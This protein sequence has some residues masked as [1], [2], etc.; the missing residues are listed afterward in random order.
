MI[1]MKKMAALLAMA[2]FVAVAI[3]AQQAPP[4]EKP[5]NLKV[6]PKNIS[7]KELDK[8]MDQYCAALGV[9]CDFCHV[10][11]KEKDEMNFVKDDKPEKQ[12]TR[13]MMRMTAAVNKTYFS[14]NGAADAQPAVTCA[15]CHRGMA[16]P[17]VADSL[18][19]K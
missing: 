3:A 1:S 7:P 17:G 4:D 16:R 13:K 19:V 9:K 10:Y 11:N 6:L 5:K 12:I 8:I 2:V 15:T 18:V 14:F